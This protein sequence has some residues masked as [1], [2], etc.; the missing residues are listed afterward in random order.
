MGKTFLYTAVCACVPR[1]VWVQ[2]P[3]LE[4]PVSR[5]NV[6]RIASPRRDLAIRHREINAAGRSEG[7]GWTLT[8]C[9]RCGWPFSWGFRV[10]WLQEATLEVQVLRE[11]VARI[12]SPRRD[13][14]IRRGR[15]ARGGYLRKLS[16]PQGRPRYKSKSTPPLRF[17]GKNLNGGARPIL[18]AIEP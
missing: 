7:A 12:A 18:A 4:V 16:F 15:V 8:N 14:A 3:T 5:E 9:S 13:L 17:R 6:V 10:C 2:E 1:V 11:N